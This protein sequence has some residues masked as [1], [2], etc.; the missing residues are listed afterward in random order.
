MHYQNN[1]FNKGAELFLFLGNV[2]NYVVYDVIILLFFFC[3]LLVFFY[4]HA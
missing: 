4:F 3:N 1:L 2:V